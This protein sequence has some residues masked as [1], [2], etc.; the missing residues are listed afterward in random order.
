[1]KNSGLCL[2]EYLGAE[3]VNL[4]K[5]MELYGEDLY[6]ETVWQPPEETA[7]TTP[8]FAGENG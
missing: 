8:T 2:E 7:S 5:A 1:M 3:A 6:L 4:E